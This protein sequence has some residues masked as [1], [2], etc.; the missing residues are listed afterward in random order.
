MYYRDSLDEQ[1]QPERNSWNEHLGSAGPHDT[2]F[3]ASDADFR[4]G[5]SLS[6]S[7]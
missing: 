3:N 1:S 7:W 4:V 6:A 2:R 5:L